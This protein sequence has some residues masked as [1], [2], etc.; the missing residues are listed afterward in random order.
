[1]LN[2]K[3]CVALLLVGLLASGV[4]AQ[5]GIHI[6]SDKTV[7]LGWSVTDGGNYRWD[8][9]QN[10]QVNDGTNDAY[11][12]GMTLQIQGSGFG[13][14]NNQATISADGREIELGPW[15]Y[16]NVTVHRRIYVEPKSSY[17]RW[18]DIFESNQ[19]M[20]LPVRYYTNVG[21]TVRMVTTT[22]GKNQLTAKDWGM[23]TA[24]EA[25]SSS[26]PAI[27]H[28]FTTRG[29][30]VRPQVTFQINNDNIYYD[31]NLEL[32]AGKPVAICTFQAQI[33]PYDQ[34]IKQMRSFSLETEMAKIPQDL[35][36]IIINMGGAVTS[37]G[38]LDLPRSEKHD[39]VV[40]ANGDQ[41]LG[42]I[43]TGEYTLDT[44]YGKLTL[45][46][47]KVLGLV[48]PTTAD[49][50]VRLGLV[51]GQVVAGKL[52]GT[53]LKIKLP[54]GDVMALA[55]SKLRSLAYKINEDKPAETACRAPL[56]VLT[57]GQQLAFDTSGVSWDFISQYGQVK[58]HP[59]MIKR[60]QLT[61][62]EGCVHTVEFRNG[63]V[64][65]GL[66][67]SE[68]LALKLALGHELKTSL[69]AMEALEMPGQAEADDS[70][71]CMTLENENVLYG[72]LANEVL[73]V[74]TVRV[75]PEAMASLAAVEEGG[76]GSVQVKMRDGSTVSGVLGEK[77]LAF[78]I[79][80]AQG[81]QEG[82]VRLDVAAS[83]ILSLE[84]PEAEG[85]AQ[86]EDSDSQPT[87]DAST[88]PTTMYSSS[89]P[90]RPTT[91]PRSPAYDELARQRA[92]AEEAEAA[93]IEAKKKEAL[94][95]E[96]KAVADAKAQQEAARQ[97]QIEA[98]S[99]QRQ[100]LIKVRDELAKNA[101]EDNSAEVAK[102]I[103]VINKEIAQLDKA[104]KE[105]SR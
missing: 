76:A 6:K 13:A 53:E 38:G 104:L 32:P 12:G 67:P 2:N 10:G 43:T 15:Q 48:V 56:A 22:S 85:S 84:M 95:A 40:L 25:G 93:A 30:R 14:P 97:K 68:Q 91:R 26:R 45:E 60:V 41:L 44:F 50:Q 28:I 23:V 75:K 62:D 31:Y 54:S 80:P 89:G 64:L 70:A 37:I 73:T 102:R 61:G 77:T 33:R 103:E 5:D 72:R 39:M 69:Q 78:I 17:C 81:D 4:A 66:L 46:A 16:G 63:S 59:A 36:A 100:Q 9:Y 83:H 105:L 57:R 47:D 55:T 96:L 94:A 92:A 19:A 71:A 74:G 1:M 20:T 82:Q 58:L 87:T 42:E 88:R 99:S 35:R 79:G 8:I 90:L 7:N 51:D 21:N 101:K 27:M 29:S 34:A 98:R 65:S 86:Q 18:I 3:V 49:G 11:D 24:A 52:S